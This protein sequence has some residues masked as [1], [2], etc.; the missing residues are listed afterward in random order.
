MSWLDS[1]THR[2]LLETAL[3]GA[4]CGAIGVHVVL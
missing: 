2:A 3:V 1:Y 4:V